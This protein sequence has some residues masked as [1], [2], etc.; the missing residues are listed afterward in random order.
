MCCGLGYGNGA[1]DAKHR[2]SQ[3][4]GYGA[5]VIIRSQSAE[6]GYHLVLSFPRGEKDRKLG[7]KKHPEAKSL[8]FKLLSIRSLPLLN[9]LGAL[10]CMLLR[11]LLICQQLLDPMRIRD[12][13]SPLNR[14]SGQ[15]PIIP[16]FEVRERVD[17][18][19]CPSGSGNPSPMTDIGD[20]A[21]VSN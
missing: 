5:R 3:L 16:S 13:P 7:F 1:V 14:R 9:P 8:L 10:L 2:G 19:A 18:N 20:C 6:E 12:M 11:C 21:F 17:I 15:H 4:G